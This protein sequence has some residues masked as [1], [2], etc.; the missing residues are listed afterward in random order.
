MRSGSTATNFRFQE[1]PSPIGV[2]F[3]IEDQYDKTKPKPEAA[4]AIAAKPV[5]PKPAVDPALVAQRDARL[6]ALVAEDLKAGRK[7]PFTVSV[8]GSAAEIVSLDDKG[9]TIRMSGGG[10]IFDLLWPDLTIQDRRNLAMARIRTTRP[11]EDLALAAFYQLACGDA[12]SAEPLL[13]GLPAADA[14]AIRA[15][16]R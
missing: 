2:A 15:L 4:K 3:I 9:G 12:K 14:E 8:M 16:A 1:P 7:T 13:R 10:S 6:R 11:A 5:E